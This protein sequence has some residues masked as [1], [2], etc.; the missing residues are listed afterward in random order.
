M[1]NIGGILY[2][3]EWFIHLLLVNLL[4]FSL[5]C[6]LQ[7]PRDILCFWSL[8]FVPNTVSIT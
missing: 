2:F 3:S 1:F 5:E 7:E 4:S 8:F 6:Q